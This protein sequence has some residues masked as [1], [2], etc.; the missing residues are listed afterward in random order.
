MFS[1]KFGRR[2]EVSD[3]RGKLLE[4]EQRLQALEIVSV[5]RSEFDPVF[6]DSYYNP[7]PTIP[8]RSAVEKLLA[9]AN[10]QWKRPAGGFLFKVTPTS[11]TKK[12]K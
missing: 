2:K 11:G 10:Y 4:L 1:T 8:L 9:D 6:I 7:P 3:V 12:G 5:P